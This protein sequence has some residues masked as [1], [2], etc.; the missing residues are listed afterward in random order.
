MNAKQLGLHAVWISLAVAPAVHAQEFDAADEEPVAAQPAATPAAPA[1]VSNPAMPS[2][3]A[4]QSAASASSGRRLGPVTLYPSI[5]IGYGYD[6]NVTLARENK[7]QSS[8]TSLRP[9][10]MGEL[11]TGDDSYRLAYA[12]DYRW[13]SSSSDDNGLNHDLQ[14][15]AANTLSS[16]LALNWGLTY[17][18]RYDPRGSTDNA[19]TAEPDQFN[20]L[21]GQFVVGYGAPD[22]KGRI[23]LG[24]NAGYKKY[25]NN[26]AT[27]EGMDTD[28]RGAS[29][30][31]FHRVMPKTSIVYEVRHN[32]IDY[33][34]S[35]SD[36][37]NREMRYLV[38]LTWDATAKTTG[39]FKVGRMTKTYERGNRGDYKGGT[40]EASIRWSPLTYSVVDFT[41]G[42]GA[43]D[44]S[45]TAVN[46]NYVLTSTYGI[47]WSHQWSDVLRSQLGWNQQKS[48]HQ[49][50][51]RKDTTN[52]YTV[53]VTYDWRRM[54]GF[55]IDYTH[56]VRD[57]SVAT[58]DYTRNLTMLKLLASF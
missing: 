29:L 16:R 36:L 43:T 18:D 20:A 56:S 15:S 35:S 58:N 28:N 32:E 3:S 14:F 9:A 34:L 33:R 5:A 57:S 48:D 40:W 23:E 52:S 17:Q 1:G 30:R 10:L 25:T 27:T 50:D 49:G 24:A 45:G 54:V 41:T 4:I 13:V 2:S 7:T 51:V 47:N 55:G 11:L 21:Q 42:R 6:D 37:D 26:R 31:F 12:G 39:S 44:P 22:A 53:G 19:V 46:T 38:G 8:F